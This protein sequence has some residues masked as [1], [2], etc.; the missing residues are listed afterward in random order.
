MNVGRVFARAGVC[1]LLAASALTVTGAPAQ[2]VTL[3]PGQV[4][5]CWGDHVGPTEVTVEYF[6]DGGVCQRP[7]INDSYLAL[8]PATGVWDGS[9]NAK[10]VQPVATL[11]A[12]FDTCLDLNATYSLITQ[13][14]TEWVRYWGGPD[15][16]VV[17]DVRNDPKCGARYAFRAPA[18]TN[19]N[20]LTLAPYAVGT[21]ICWGALTQHL[22]PGWSLVSAPVNPSRCAQDDPTTVNTAFLTRT[23]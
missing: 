5:R 9:R 12:P 15:G 14:S 20:T 11:T 8:N 3:L 19:E 1:G 13:Y 2:A 22:E 21:E 4:T 17:T 16:Y 7:T 18:N 23:P 6:D 10:V